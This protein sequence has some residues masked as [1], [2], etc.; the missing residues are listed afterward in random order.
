MVLFRAGRL[1]SGLT[2]LG[3]TLLLELARLAYYGYPCATFSHHF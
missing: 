3:T 2:F 1:D